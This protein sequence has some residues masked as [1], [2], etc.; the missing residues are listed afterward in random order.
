LQRVAL[1]ESRP[2]STRGALAR[3]EDEIVRDACIQRFEFT[4]EMAWRAVQRFAQSEGLDR[5]SPRECFRIAFRLGLIDKDARWM[6][7]FEDR[8]RAAHTYDE[9]SA[10]TIYCALPGYAAPFSQLLG[11]LEERESRRARSDA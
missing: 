1:F 5:V 2:G 6:V 4:F 8:N 3:P 10:R 11:R 7:M 9:A